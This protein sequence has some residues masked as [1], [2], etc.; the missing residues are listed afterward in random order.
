MVRPPIAV[1]C[2]LFVEL[3]TGIWALRCFGH[4]SS[5]FGIASMD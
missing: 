5:R 4:G 2:A 1:V 3:A